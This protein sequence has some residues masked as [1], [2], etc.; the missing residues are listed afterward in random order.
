MLVKEII[1]F[2]KEIQLDAFYHAVQI[3]IKKPQVVNRKLNT[4][5]NVLTAK[6][7]ENSENL[8][9]LLNSFSDETFELTGLEYTIIKLD[10]E[11][12][13][14]DANIEE[15]I[16]SFDKIIPRNVTKYKSC[17]QLTIFCKSINLF[18]L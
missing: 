6:T 3:Y 5:T 8:L 11:L 15:I 17:Y 1:N 12:Q 4:A 13:H 10:D 18:G 14:I 9:K 7:R 16:F 2:N